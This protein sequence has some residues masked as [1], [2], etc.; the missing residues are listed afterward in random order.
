MT[1]FSIDTVKYSINSST[2]MGINLL[3]AVTPNDII[4]GFPVNKEVSD[5][6]VAFGDY[7]AISTYI[8]INELPNPMI[9]FSGWLSF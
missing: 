2:A 7:K 4:Y 5:Y 1:A 3:F 9:S 6:S 8:P